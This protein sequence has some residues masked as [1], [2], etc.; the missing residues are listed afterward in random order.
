MNFIK[1]YPVTL[2]FVSSLSWSIGI[3]TL[4]I[5]QV[6]ELLDLHLSNMFAWIGLIGP[7][8]CAIVLSYIIGGKKELVQFFKPLLRW[9]VPLIYYVFVYIGVFFFYCAASWFTILLNGTENVHSL[10]WLLENTKAPFFGLHGL[11]VVI[12]ITIIYTVCEELGWRGF[13]LPKMTENSN[14]LL[15]AFVLGIFWTLW[16]VPLIYLYGSSFDISSASIYFLHIECM[17]IYYAWLYFKTNK[18]LL[19][20]GLF[21]G[22]TDGI[23]AFFPVTVAAIGQGPNTPT[24]SFEIIIALLMIPYLVKLRPAVISTK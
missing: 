11:W 12:E 8:F 5:P 23:G 17:S 4:L 7:G 3:W 21:H 18:S 24:L 16:H 14:V 6:Q 15:S 1:K 9:K 20:C 10:S 19:M 22:A 2:F 13:A